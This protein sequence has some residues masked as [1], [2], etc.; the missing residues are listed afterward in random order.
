MME[1]NWVAVSVTHCF[2]LLCSYITEANR[3]FLISI[4]IYMN[5]HFILNPHILSVH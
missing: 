3:G 4:P 1:V 2:Q 5:M